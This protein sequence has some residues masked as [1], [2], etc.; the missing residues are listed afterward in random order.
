VRDRFGRDFT[1]LRVSVTDRCNLYCTYC[2]APEAPR[3]ERLAAEEILRI[4]RVAASLG[5]VKVRLTG[6]E[7][8]LRSDLVELTRAVA[9]TPGIREVVMTTNGLKLA[10]LADPLASA[11]LSRVNVSCDS[12]DE[13][14]F[15]AITR[16]GPL[17]KVLEGIDAALAAGLGVKVNCVVLGG[18]NDFEVGAFVGF[19]IERGIDV[20]FI[21][22]MPMDPADLDGISGSTKTVP[23]AVLRERVS[24]RWRLL[25]EAGGTSGGPAETYRV[26]GTGSRVG[27]ISAMSNPFCE[28][29]NRLRITPEGKIRSCLLTGEEIDLVSAVRRGADDDEL[30]ELFASALERKPPVFEL[31][32]AGAVAMRA[33]GG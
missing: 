24:A 27:F 18:T 26:A 33:I 10:G 4:V 11:G 17:R 22:Y 23:S 19:A 21:E 5:V 31:H 32:R 13:A 30:A 12:L 2:K 3:P 16:G 14:R 7:P 28:S 1:Y 9:R 20:R 15:A 29:C 6:G 25:P 8:T